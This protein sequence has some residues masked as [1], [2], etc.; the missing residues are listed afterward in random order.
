MLLASALASSSKRARCNHAGGS[1]GR[2]ASCGS[3]ARECSVLTL[4]PLA[5]PQ[6]ELTQAAEGLSSYAR[7]D[8][9]SLRCARTHH[10]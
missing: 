9:H 3:T 2:R 7:G 8:K 5:Q 6:R 4:M 10:Y 1:D